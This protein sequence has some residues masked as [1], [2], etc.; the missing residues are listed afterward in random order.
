MHAYT[1]TV[2]KMHSYQHM[3]ATYRFSPATS[4]Q[5]DDNILESA[6]DS[7]TLQRAALVVRKLVF[8]TLEQLNSN[9]D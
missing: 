9:W 2:R 3:H 5:I 7:G 1:H 8:V 4:H 6:A